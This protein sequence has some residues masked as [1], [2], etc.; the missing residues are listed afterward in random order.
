MSELNNNEKKLN[1][2][3]VIPQKQDF[4]KIKKNF[5]YLEKKEDVEKDDIIESKDELDTDSINTEKNNIINDCIINTD[6]NKNKNK[7]NIN[8]KDIKINSNTKSKNTYD[9]SSSKRGLKEIN[10]IPY[11]NNLS[12]LN[13]D[14]IINDSKTGKKKELDDNKKNDTGKEKKSEEKFDK[15]EKEYSK[16]KLTIF[17]TKVLYKDN[18]NIIECRLLLYKNELFIINNKNNETI[19]TLLNT[20]ENNNNNNNYNGNN[21]LFEEE[22]LFMLINK[23]Y[24]VSNPLFYINFDL[25]T[26]KLLLNKK[27]KWI[28]ILIFNC[29]NSIN[30]FI[31]NIN[32]YNKFIYLVNERICNSEGNKINLVELT[33]KTPS[34]IHN[35]YISVTEFQSMAK[36]GD[37]ILF[38]TKSCGASF[39]RLYTRDT[40]DHVA[41]IENNKGDISLFQASL[42]GDTCYVFWDFLLI[43]SYFWLYDLVTYRRLNYEAETEE[44]LKNKQKE[45]EKKFDEFSKDTNGM[46]YYISIKNMVCCD[47]IDETQRKGE[48]KKMK[49]FSCS[50]LASAFYTKIGAIKYTRNIHSIKPGD[51]QSNKNTLSFND[52][53]SFGPEKIIDFSEYY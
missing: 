11:N 8:N 38:K 44:E 52:K 29:N 33:Y 32:D 22:N 14:T 19:E 3:S 26:C 39:Q 36:T 4:V 25:L 6:I 5:T 43:G 47:G 28:K 30:L 37:L 17:F 41:L 12:F 16:R 50:A 21:K 23:N 51:F 13:E 49:G 27:T 40:Y 2:S 24:D 45:I 7:K 35:N 9:S 46:K 48:W 1:K 20:N 53:F 42:N 10:F 31:E 34:F 18:E 15:F